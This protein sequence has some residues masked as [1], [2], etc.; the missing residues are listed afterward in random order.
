MIRV[1][2]HLPCE[3]RLKQFGLISL[4][5]KSFQAHLTEA[6]QYFKGSTEKIGRDSLSGCVVVR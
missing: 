5:N 3:D 1:L 2:K 4:E 6:L